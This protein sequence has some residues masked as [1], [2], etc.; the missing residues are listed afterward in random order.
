V[1][2][3]QLSGDESSVNDLSSFIA[4][5]CSSSRVNLVKVGHFQY[6]HNF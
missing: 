4:A 6:F 3:R 5:E 1:A 2:F